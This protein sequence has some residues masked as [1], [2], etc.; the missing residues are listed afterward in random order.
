VHEKWQPKRSNRKSPLLLNRKTSINKIERI[1]MEDKERAI[2]ELTKLITVIENK[3]LQAT[4]LKIR[5]SKNIQ[6]GP[7][8]S[9]GYTNSTDIEGCDSVTIASIDATAPEDL[10]IV[11]PIIIEMIRALKSVE[12]PKVRLTEL[13]AKIA[14]C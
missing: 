14:L 10:E 2:T 11:K 5:N 12:K 7:Y 8:T 9:K 4:G 6:I 1:I 3:T 13:F